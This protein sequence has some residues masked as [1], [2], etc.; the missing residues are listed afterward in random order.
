LVFT[1]GTATAFW[2]LGHDPGLELLAETGG[3]N[4]MIITAMSDRDLAIKHVVHSAFGHA[5][6]KCSATSLLI[7]ERE[8]YEDETFRET[9]CDAAAS[10]CVGSA[11]QLKTIVGPLIRP[12]SGALERGLKELEEGESWALRPRRIDRNP[13]IWSP[14]IKWGVQPES[15]SH[16]TELFGPVL[17]V[18]CARDLDEAIDLVHRT[19]YG[20]TSGL[21]SLD[22][23]EQR[24]W[25][26]RVRAGNLYQNRGTT[27]AIVLRQ[28]FGG[29]AR[30]AIG[31]GLKAGGPNYVSAL[32]DFRERPVDAAD[33]HGKV[34]EER[35]AGLLD[36]LDRQST[37][38]TSA[39]A[40]L[41]RAA[42]SYAAAVEAEF[43]REHDSFR[44]VGQDNLR[45]YL[46]IGSMRIRVEVGDTPF[47]L[48]A[49]VLAASA[50]GCAIT[51]STP[52]DLAAPEVEILN[53]LTE[54]WGASIEFIEE[55]D[56]T[57]AEVIRE[58]QT[59]RVR[60]A[61]SDRVGLDV[62][63]AAAEMGLYLATA[64]VLSVGRIELLHYVREQ[65]LCIDYHRYGNLGAR[66][67]EE[68][69]Q[70]L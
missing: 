18:M 2:L 34:S 20:L 59:E 55:S 45:R 32:M 43:G 30:S 44:L 66:S 63:R 42:I 7:L 29:M 60:Y 28:P 52:R 69:E 40:R 62:L 15:F 64:P 39:F 47:D 6:Q 58:G 31:P 25:A 56:A 11:W 51:V 22:D 21:A 57:L 1:G 53:D 26:E 12:V 36:D 50:A 14:G 67:V 38:D 46:P 8:V 16:Q 70:G 24:H 17:G 48:F 19:G 33:S 65:S 37:L 9:L 41:R 10:L 3:K 35:V 61:L 13:Q 49:R 68:R 5:G 4:A 27:G 23:R 54:S